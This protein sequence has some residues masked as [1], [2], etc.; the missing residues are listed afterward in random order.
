MRAP[1]VQ[2]SAV[3]DHRYSF[4]LTSIL[5]PSG[6]EEDF[7]RKNLFCGGSRLVLSEVE[8]VSLL[9]PNYKFPAML[10]SVMFSSA[11]S[12]GREMA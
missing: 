1:S 9:C 5:S 7:T 10:E 8:W 6:E 11:T 12:T 3:A 4:A 2:N